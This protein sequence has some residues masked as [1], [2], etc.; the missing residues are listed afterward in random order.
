MSTDLKDEA[1]T[2]YIKSAIHIERLPLF[3]IYLTTLC[4]LHKL[5]GKMSVDDEFE[6][7]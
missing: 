3:L 5:Y 7:M 4:L 1:F 2:S 6:S